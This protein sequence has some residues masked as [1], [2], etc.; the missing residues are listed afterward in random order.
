MLLTLPPIAHAPAPAPAPN[1]AA[2]ELRYPFGALPEP[3]AKRLESV[4]RSVL[5]DVTAVPVTNMVAAKASW[6]LADPAAR[7]RIGDH[8]R[9]QLEALGASRPMEDLHD[10]LFATLRFIPRGTTLAAHL[11]ASDPLGIGHYGPISVAFSSDALDGAM[12]LPTLSISVDQ[13]EGYARHGMRARPS[14]DLVQSVAERVA[15]DHGFLQQPSATIDERR[16]AFLDVLGGPDPAARDYVRSWLTSSRR[17]DR[18]Y[19]MEAILKG[20]QPSQI[21]A[22]AI[23]HDADGEEARAVGTAAAARGIEVIDRHTRS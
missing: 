11:G 18:N 2:V 9:P 23:E 22:V 14:R 16:S 3:A 4:I 20:V 15:M 7:F 8:Y 12:L 5:P 1:R 13:A 10:A 21:R 17:A 6:L 19:A